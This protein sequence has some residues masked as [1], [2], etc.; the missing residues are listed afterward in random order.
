V[1]NC[2]FDALTFGTRSKMLQEAHARI[3]AAPDQY[4]PEIYGENEVGGTSWL[5]LA[6]VPFDQ[7]GFKTD[8]GATAYPELAKPFLY[9][10]PL[11]LTLGPAFLLGLSNATKPE[12]EMREEEASDGKHHLPGRDVA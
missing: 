5:Y 1:Q 8:L 6:S 9:T 3:A 11:V 12:P 2:P 10:V 4:V 7:L